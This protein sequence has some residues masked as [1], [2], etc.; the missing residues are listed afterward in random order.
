MLTK[1]EIRDRHY[2]AIFNA[3]PYH[4]CPFCGCEYF[5]APGAPRT[6]LDH[7]LAKNEYPFAVVNLSNLVPM[8]NKCNSKY[9]LAT[10]ILH[11]EDGTRRKAFYPYDEH[12]G[13]QVSLNRSDPFMGKEEIC[14]A[15]Q[16]DFMPDCE[17]VA[18][19]DEVFHIRERYGRDILDEDFM[20]WLGEFSSWCRSANIRH[21]SDQDI[22]D[23]LKRYSGYME[24]MSMRDRAFLKAAVFQMLYH[25]C[26]Q[27]HQR[28]FTLI[29]G[30]VIARMA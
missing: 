18:T 10:D 8:G 11:R 5:D 30:V 14:P 2:A 22:L 26:E 28:L 24:M 29:K 12:K 19:W 9:K 6:D 4:L 27:G 23:A 20:S 13:I 25:H 21:V 1:L 3:T 16:I 15:W 7:Y 17:E